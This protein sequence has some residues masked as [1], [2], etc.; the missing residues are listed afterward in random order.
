M[1]SATRRTGLDWCP[2]DGLEELAFCCLMLLRW[3]KN[4]VPKGGERQAMKRLNLNQ[5]VVDLKAEVADF[6]AEDAAR[7]EAVMSRVVRAA[8]KGRD[9]DREQSWRDRAE[10]LYQARFKR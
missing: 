8:T 3:V 1:W 9:M 2:A 5:E 4:N 6:K 7:D 10:R